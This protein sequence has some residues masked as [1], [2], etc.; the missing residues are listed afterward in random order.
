MTTSFLHF[1]TQMTSDGKDRRIRCL[2]FG[3][4]RQEAVSKIMQA[5]LNSSALLCSV[6]ASL[7]GPNGL[8]EIGFVMHYG[9]ELSG[10]LSSERKLFTGKNTI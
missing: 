8:T 5:A 10:S 7:P 9:F 1:P 2:G 3:Q 6:P 4:V